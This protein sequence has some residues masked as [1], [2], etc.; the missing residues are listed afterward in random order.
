MS[1]IRIMIADDV[2]E[3]RKVIKK[4]LSIEKNSIEVVGEV[5]NGEDAFK[6]V[7]K[8]KPD[9]ILMDIN[10]PKMNGLEATEKIT[11]NYPNIIVIIMSVQ[12]ESE[13]LKGAMFSGAKEYIIKPFNYNDLTQTIKVTFEKYKDMLVKQKQEEKKNAKIVT[14]YS[15]K[16]GV[17]KTLLSLNSGISLSNKYKKKTLLIDMDL[18]YGD[19]SIMLNKHTGMNIV[20][21]IDQGKWDTYES[22][23]P[24]LYKH[25]NNLDVLLAPKNPDSSEYIGKEIVEKIINSLRTYYDVIIIDTGVNFSDLTLY[26]LDISDVILFVSYMEI[27]SLKNTKIGLGI[28]NT[29]NYDDQKVKL[30]INGLTNKYGINKKDLQEAFKDSIFSMIPEDLKNS[31][32]SINRGIPICENPKNKNNKIVKAI[33]EMCKKLIDLR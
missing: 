12:G 25:N 4:I 1:K 33:N 7:P 31:R 29:I 23:E 32:L 27:V 2:E 18:Q 16:G 30:V 9:V 15:S 5:S 11:Q 13:Y 26:I 24:Y 21:L 14:F 17:G 28:M 22:I 3:T 8:L 6:M 10:M 20:D 19:I